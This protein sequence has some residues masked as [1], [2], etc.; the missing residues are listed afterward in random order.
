MEVRELGHSVTHPGASGQG[1]GIAALLGQDYALGLSGD[2]SA[3]HL[4]VMPLHAGLDVKVGPVHAVAG[5]Y[6]G[7]VGVVDYPEAE[8][9]HLHPLD[10]EYVLGLRLFLSFGRTEPEDAG[11]VGGVLLSGLGDER[12]AGVLDLGGAQLDAVLREQALEREARR[13]G[14]GA[15]EGVLR[16]VDVTLPGVVVQHRQ[17]LDHHAVEGDEGDVG[18]LDAAVDLVF[19]RLEHPPH[20]GGLCGRELQHEHDGQQQRYERYQDAGEYFKCLS[21]TGAVLF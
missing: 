20:E 6:V 12:Q 16:D 15:E 17:V 9:L 7:G 3:G 2:D 4:E 10:G 1:A 13:Y 18:E 8:V 5:L 14:P 19:E 11:E 21:D